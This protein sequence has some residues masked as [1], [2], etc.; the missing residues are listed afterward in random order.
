MAAQRRT[1][2]H[3]ASKG[4]QS[5]PP[6]QHGPN[7]LKRAYTRHKLKAGLQER[8][9]V[10]SETLPRGERAPRVGVEDCQAK[11]S[12]K[13]VH[14]S[15]TVCGTRSANEMS[16]VLGFGMLVSPKLVQCFT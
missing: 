14:G 5:T 8:P 13:Q 1:S 4:C 3:S 2:P 7:A 12:A 10:G 11:G 6:A 9:K 15:F 16:A